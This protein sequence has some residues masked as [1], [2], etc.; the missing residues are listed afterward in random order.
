MTRRFPARSAAHEWSQQHLSHY[1]EGELSWLARRRLQLHAEDCPECSRGLLALRSLV[2]LLHG[3]ADR[4]NEQAPASI[5]DRVRAE[6]AKAD[7]G[8]D[9]I[10]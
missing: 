2:R 5:L 8:S 9:E 6:A 10:N 1:V 3:M 4:P 7:L